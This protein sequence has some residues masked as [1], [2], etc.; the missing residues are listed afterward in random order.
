MERVTRAGSWA[1]TS[2]RVSPAAARYG[3]P[4]TARGLGL[5]LALLVVGAVGGYAYADLGHGTTRSGSAPTPV[6]AADPELPFTPPEKVNADSDAP[7]VPTSLTTED[8]TVGRGPESVVLPVP[9]AWEQIRLSGQ[10][11]RWLA[12][13]RPAGSYSVRVQAVDQ[14]RS[15]AQAVA[16]RAAA[17]PLDPSVSD[18][19]VID[20][21]VDTLRATFI[22][23]G[24]RKLTI[25]RWVSFEGGTV[26]LEIAATGRLI[27]QPGLEALVARMATEARRPPTRQQAPAG[28]SQ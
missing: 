9:A 26:D 13:G 19:E 3:D 15:L 17:L 24:Y 12:P 10:E 25:I 4:M 23:A 6:A 7:P 16:E 28:G 20:Q 2:P 14:R 11:S 27:D 8:A 21:S 22:L 18:L 5:L 1:G